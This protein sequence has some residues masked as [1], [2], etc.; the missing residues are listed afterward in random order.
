MIKN[1]T[2]EL[3]AILAAVE[4]LPEAG[5]E[6]NPVVEPLNVTENGTYNAPEGVDGYNPVTVYVPSK[7][8]VLQSKT[9]TPSGVAESVTP[10]SG[11]DGLSLVRINGE[12]NLK[13]ENIV[14]DETVYGV[15]GTAEPASALAE[16]AT[17]QDELIDSIMTALQ[18]KAVGGGVPTCTVEIINETVGDMYPS[19]LRELWFVAY[20]NGE[21]VWYG[22]DNDSVNDSSN[23][24]PVGFNWLSERYVLTN[25]VCGSMMR[26]EDSQGALDIPY[27]FFVNPV[28]TDTMVMIPPTP[29]ATYTFKI[30]A[31]WLG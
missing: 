29:D 4:A 12:P 18:G 15:V 28:I 22:G 30:T 13:P 17:R 10:D 5:G 27:E 11:Y 8:P 19:Y 25:V 9:Y 6:A 7:E 14:A 20:E 2:T 21:Y 31:G 1:N 24:L 3:Q 26:I 23:K 16:T